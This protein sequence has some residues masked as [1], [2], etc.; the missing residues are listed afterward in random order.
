MSILHALRVVAACLAA[1]TPRA[2]GV[3]WRHGPAKLSLT[4]RRSERAVQSYKLQT[5][6][7]VD[8]VDAPFTQGL[9]MTA[10]GGQLIETTGAYPAGTLSY[11]RGLCPETGKELWRSDDGVG[12]YFLE[13]IAQLDAKKNFFV[14]TNAVPYKVLEYGPD[15]V[16]KKTYDLDYEGWGF[17]RTPD[18]K[19]YFATNG[20]KMVMKLSAS[21]F[22]LIDA[23]PV[24]C[25][26][27]D[28]RGLNELEMVNDFMGQGPRLLGNVYLSRHALILDPD[29]MECTG[30]FSLD[31]L[32]EPIQSGEGSGFHA[33][34][35]IA[36]EQK[37]GSLYLT[38][39][40]WK[41]LYKAELV[42]DSDETS[43]KSF[44]LWIDGSKS[45][46]LLQQTPRDASTF[47]PGAKKL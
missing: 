43:K 25:L 5:L 3:Y 1:A 21:D 26:G 13:G 18:G 32:D 19:N 29:T 7:K 28:V 27:F 10:D 35:G 33:A 20:S 23:K 41:S 40:N 17:A 8:H 47:L 31:D 14:T 46:A 24:R 9:E 34:N 30:T 12:S 4:Q 22:K 42:E 36:Y 44:K 45:V 15:F 2:A 11:I 39:K 16:L 6:R 37:T 38:G